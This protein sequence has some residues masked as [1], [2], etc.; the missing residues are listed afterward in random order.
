ASREVV[1]GEG[2]PA[3]GARL[4]LEAADPTLGDPAAAGHD[5]SGRDDEGAVEL[6]QP[7]R[8][9]E[10]PQ[11][12]VD[13]RVRGEEREQTLEVAGVDGGQVALRG[14]AGGVHGL[15]LSWTAVVEGD[16]EPADAG[17]P[18][19]AGPLHGL[20]H[21]AGREAGEQLREDGADREPG[22]A[23]AEAEV[24]A[25]TEPEVGVGGAGDVEDVRIGALRPGPVG[26]PLPDQHLV[27]GA[28]PLPAELAVDRR[29]TPL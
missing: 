20:G 2:A 9:L 16:G 14:G 28:D 4:E 12:V 22:E 15:L 27:A 17:V 3:L 18:V 25:L 24:D 13:D 8:P 6:P 23:R 11:R 5:R 1:G 10:G 29:R 26:R 21:A 19:A 7:V